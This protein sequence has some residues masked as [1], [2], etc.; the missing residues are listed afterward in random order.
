[1]RSSTLRRLQSCLDGSRFRARGRVCPDLGLLNFTLFVLLRRPMAAAALSLALMAA[2]ILLSQFK[3]GIL[4]MTV[5]F[6][7][8]M[9]MIS[10]ASRS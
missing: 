1:M 7:D 2:L 6:L 9:I 8:I 3:H 4:L 10:T 5:N